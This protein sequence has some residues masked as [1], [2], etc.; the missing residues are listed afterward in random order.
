M[1]KRSKIKITLTILG[2]IALVLAIAAWVF[3][4]F[5]FESTLNKVVIPKIE[6][7]A[8][9]ATHGRFVLTLDKIFYRHG[10]LIC[11][12]FVLSRVAYDSTEHGMVLEKV[13][14]DS[15]RFQGISWWDM[16]WQ[17]DI[18]MTSLDL[19]AP[20][21][22]MIDIDTGTLLPLIPK[23]VPIKNATPSNVPILSFDSIVLRTAIIFLPKQ[24]GK[25][26]EPTY[27]D[28][29][30]KLTDFSLDPKRMT[31]EPAFFSQRVDFELPGGSYSMGDSLYS[32]NVRGIRGSFSDSLV[33]IDSFGYEPNYNEDAFANKHKYIQGRLEFRCAGI[34]L[35]GIDFTKLL[36]GGGLHARSLKAASWYV[37][38]YGD[39]RK[40]V[41]PHPPNAVLPHTII[42]SIKAKVTIDS[43][44]LIDGTIHH[45]ERVA[46][47][48]HASLLTFTHARV[49]AQPFC[50]DASSPLYKDPLRIS[51]KALFMGQ[52]KVIG[53]ILY[54]IHQ[55]PFDLHVV[56]TV[57]PFDARVLNSYLISNERKQV[58]K[59][60]IL[61]G[62]IRMDVRSGRG[63]TMV[64]PRYSDLSMEIMSSDV[65]KSRGILE[66]IKTFIANTFVLRTNN[67]D[68]ANSKAVSETTTTIRTSKQ[69]FFEYIWIAMRKSILKVLGF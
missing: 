1:K 11:N 57:G 65:K 62:E 38:Y 49:A 43:I 5:Y 59:G 6:L 58:M 39:L 60:N 69:E 19:K 44:V 21:L 2:T 13:T 56:A 17:K 45:R 46:G 26:S 29:T 24:A 16:L 48:S 3:N 10:T 23:Y 31:G 28:I 4:T 34:E 12:S 8:A 61:G 52:G 40:P 63:I 9:K 37:D 27:R 33:T 25:S 50:T 53:T 68:K 35:R 18:S 67:V 54:P 22:Y 55:K 41:D 47:S 20:K 32:L 30:I 36:T 51:L 15:A 66:G 7:A 14:L 64:S 42:N